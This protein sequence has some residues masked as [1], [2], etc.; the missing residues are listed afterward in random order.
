MSVYGAESRAAT[1][2]TGKG[3]WREHKPGQ[4]RPRAV[5]PFRLIR[6]VYGV[7]VP[8]VTRACP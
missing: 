7:F 8:A 3:T 4:A 5:T 1:N 2:E 6:S